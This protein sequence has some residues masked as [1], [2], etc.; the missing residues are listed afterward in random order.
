[1]HRV[2]KPGG[3]FYFEEVLRG[4]LETRIARTLFRHPE[5]GHFT[6]EEFLA[7]CR[8]SGLE[9]MSSVTEIGR[10]FAIGVAGRRAGEQPAPVSR[11]R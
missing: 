1:V 7:A 9:P 4:F 3:R 8:E 5:E 6:T 10:W 2:L 11:P